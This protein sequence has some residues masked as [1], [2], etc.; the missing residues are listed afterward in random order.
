MTAE[1]LILFLLILTNGFFSLS[2]MA[3]VSARKVRLQQRAEEGSNAARTALD[4]AGRPTRF[5]STVQIGITLIGIL[6]G[7]FGGATVAETLAAYF[8][9]FPALE[10]YSE[11]LA[12]GIVVTVITYFSLVLGEIVPKRLALSNA[13]K[14]AAQVAPIMQ[15]L[16][17]ISGPL[18]SLLSASTEFVVRLLGI[19]PASEPTVTEEEV[20]ILIEQGRETGVFEDVEQE[21]VERVFRLSDRSVNSLMTHRSEMVWLDVEDPLEENIKK[22]LTPGKRILWFARVNSIT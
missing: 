21:M 13:E 22:I 2:E 12:V 5:L 19:K 7:A 1:I 4:L 8:A 10:P 17:T 15:F 6:S 3:I 20:K 18:V 14:I 11:A 9:Q 16:S